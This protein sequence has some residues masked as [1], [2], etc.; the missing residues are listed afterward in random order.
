MHRSQA[1]RRLSKDA[2]SRDRTILAMNEKCIGTGEHIIETGVLSQFWY[3][4]LYEACWRLGLLGLG[5]VLETG[6][7]GTGMVGLLI[8]GAVLETGTVG[9]GMVGLLRLSAVLETGTVGAGMVELGTGEL[10]A[11]GLVAPRRW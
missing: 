7:V 4:R 3:R 1:L 11:I 5:M 10:G 8:L 9:T 2:G 6:T